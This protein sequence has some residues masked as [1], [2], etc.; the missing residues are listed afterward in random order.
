MIQS[1]LCVDMSTSM[2]Y[3]HVD[4]EKKTVTVGE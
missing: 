4:P 3:V 1:S 2:N